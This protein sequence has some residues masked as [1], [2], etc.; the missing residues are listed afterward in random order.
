MARIQVLPLTPQRLGDVEETPFILV[1][2]QVEPGTYDRPEMITNL[3][4]STGA[5]TVLI[6]TGETLEVVGGT[7]LPEDL[8]TTITQRLS[9]VVVLTDYVGNEVGRV[10][11]T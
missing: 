10:P 8:V 9:D 2:D 3:I 7:E 4:Q 6:I 5:R 11:T 1:I